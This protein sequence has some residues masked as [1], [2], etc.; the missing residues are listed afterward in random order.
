MEEAQISFDENFYGEALNQAEKA[1]NSKKY[2][3]EYE[4][5]VLENRIV[6]L[7]EESQINDRLT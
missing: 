3:S 2:Q 6:F 4:I 5:Y 7:L 1:K